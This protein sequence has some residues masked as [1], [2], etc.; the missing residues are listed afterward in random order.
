VTHIV[1]DTGP[2]GNGAIVGGGVGVGLETAVSLATALGDSLGFADGVPA[3]QAA[4][5]SVAAA[6][7]ASQERVLSDLA[8]TGSRRLLITSSIAFRKRFR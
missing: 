7:T 2:V 1:S 8:P 6:A 5:M 4:S 3:P